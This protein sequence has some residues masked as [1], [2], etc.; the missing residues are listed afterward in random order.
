LKDIDKTKESVIVAFNLGIA[1]R[2]ERHFAGVRA[3][4]GYFNEFIYS[5][6][7]QKYLGIVDEGLIK[8]KAEYLTSIAILGYILPH[9]CS[10]D[11]E[12]KGRLVEIIM[13]KLRK[14]REVIEFEEIKKERANDLHQEQVL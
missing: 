14:P 13:K 6:L 7:S 12:F 10:H 5:N 3:A 11:E 2:E 8:A 9:L 1:A 4:A